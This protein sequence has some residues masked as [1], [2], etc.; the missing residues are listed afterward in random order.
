MIRGKK[1]KEEW[2]KQT[3]GYRMTSVIALGLIAVFVT[4]ILIAFIALRVLD[5]LG[6]DISKLQDPRIALLNFFLVSMVYAVLATYIIMRKIF[7]PIEE[8]SKASQQVAKGDYDVQLQ[9][10]GKVEELNKA[11]NNFNKMVKELNSVE[12]MSNDFIADVSHEFKTPLSAISGYA[13][14][15]QDP[16]LSDEE[17]AD[18][19]KKIFFNIDKLNDLTENILRLSKLEHQQYDNEPV[20][21]RLDEQIREAVVF[22]EPKWNKKAVK[23][24]IDMPE[25]TFKGQKVLLFLVW[26]NII[27]NAIKYTDREGKITIQIKEKNDN[28]KVMVSDT[29]IGM[30]E[31][32][33][34]HIFDKFYQGDT[35]RKSQGNGLGLPL[36]KEIVKRCGGDIYVESTV[37]VG[38][39]FI[40]KLPIEK[41][42]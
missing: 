24:D 19:I 15:L 35:S 30:S 40:V 23:F 21:Y 2:E 11:I 33:Q 32:T 38:S 26:T 5:G 1:S 13:T 27:G 14:F 17:K 9:Y 36:C 8:L 41:N 29:G 37:G 16:E 22:L 20:T 31:E 34:K 3:R 6:Y 25:I 28:V 4:Y 12:I 39:V 42:M 18:Y 10:D 7:K